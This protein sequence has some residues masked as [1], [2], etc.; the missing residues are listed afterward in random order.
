L[1]ACAG[2]TWP[3]LATPGCRASPG[4]PCV[5]GLPARP[6]GR[7]H[8]LHALNVPAVVAACLWWLVLHHCLWWLVLHHCLW[9]LV[10][11]HCPSVHSLP[12]RVLSG[13]S[14]VL[15]RQHSP[16][17]A[18]GPSHLPH[19]PHL[20]HLPQ[21]L[22]TSTSQ[23]MAP[24]LMGV[25]RPHH[26][27]R[28]S[29]TSCCKDDLGRSKVPRVT[30]EGTV[31]MHRPRGPRCCHHNVLSVKSVCHVM[32]PAVTITAGSALLHS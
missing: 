12:V 24:A 16:P 19:L 18:S 5:E 7:L 6:A 25:L 11:H 26:T 8:C 28:A 30:K 9:W 1:H 10:L 15:P 22:L 32:V 17:L 13:H 3:H 23:S 20:S 14:L 29:I 4:L 31:P 21:A 2:H 27:H